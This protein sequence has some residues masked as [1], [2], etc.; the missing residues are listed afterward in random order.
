VASELLEKQWRFARMVPI[1]ILAAHGMGYNVTI[2]EVERH[3]SATHGH[4]KSTHR[5]RLAIDLHLFLDDQYL[6]D[7]TGH[8]EL[9]NL[10]DSLGGAKRIAG[11]LNHYSLSH[12]GVR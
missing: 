9:H 8:H 7:G 10:W 1:L 12:D 5:V 2:G 3:A 4:P 11:D 6:T